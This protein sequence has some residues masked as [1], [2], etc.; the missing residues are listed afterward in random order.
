L[1]IIIRKK[2][3][4]KEDMNLRQKI[5]ENHVEVDVVEFVII[6]GGPEI[7]KGIKW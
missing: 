7:R 1:A 6:V 3:I 5:L 4:V 2:L